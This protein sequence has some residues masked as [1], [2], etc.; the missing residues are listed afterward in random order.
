MSIERKTYSVSCVRCPISGL[1]PVFVTE[2]KKCSFYSG[3]K[4]TSEDTVVIKCDGKFS[5]D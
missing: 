1:L 4:V 3:M 2:C 5:G